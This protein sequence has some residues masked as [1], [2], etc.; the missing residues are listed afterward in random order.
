[1]TTSNELAVN[2][3]PWDSAPAW[4]KAVVRDK[5]DDELAWVSGIEQGSYI[6]WVQKELNAAPCGYL[7]TPNQVEL[8]EIK[9]D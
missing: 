4:C 9:P 5:E 1:M 7:T 6:Q 2:D 3:I 8:Y